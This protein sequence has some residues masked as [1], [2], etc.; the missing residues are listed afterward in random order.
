M[1]NAKWISIYREQFR[2]IK[3]LSDEQA[4]VL[5]KALIDFS[6]TG[7]F[8]SGLEL[9]VDILLDEMT[10]KIKRDEET[11]EKKRKQMKGLADKRWHA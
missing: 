6:D 8:P 1:S 5:L 9:V 7:K 4:G 11:Y 2:S 3:R 10:S